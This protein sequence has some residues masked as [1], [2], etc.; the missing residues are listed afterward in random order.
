MA[1]KPLVL[2]RTHSEWDA[3]QGINSTAKIL[4]INKQVGW[5]EIK[6]FAV[7]EGYQHG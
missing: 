7:L 1:D 4:D 2:P 5:P 6:Q 3:V